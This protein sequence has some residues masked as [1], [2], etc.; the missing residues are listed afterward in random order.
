MRHLYFRAIMAIVWLA[1]AIISLLSGILEFAALYVLLSAA[2]SY[3]AYT[4]WKKERGGRD[5]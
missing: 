4:M 5:E 1:A 2:F 3:S